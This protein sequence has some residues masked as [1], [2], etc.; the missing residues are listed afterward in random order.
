EELAHAVSLPPLPV[1]GVGI[2]LDDDPEDRA[3]KLPAEKLKEAALEKGVHQIGPRL[4]SGILAQ[5]GKKANTPWQSIK[6]IPYSGVEMRL[7]K[8]GCVE[9]TSGLGSDEISLA[10]LTISANGTT[11]KIDPFT[12]SDDFDAGESVQFGLSIDVSTGQVT[13]TG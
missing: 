1:E 12:V 5:L 8:M 13:N 7:I 11:S 3:I 4:D 9:T 6:P 10:G 2:R